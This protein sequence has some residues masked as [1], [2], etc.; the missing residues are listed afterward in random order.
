MKVE[1]FMV[2]VEYDT[3]APLVIIVNTFDEAME[4]KKEVKECYR[5]GVHKFSG[6]GPATEILTEVNRG[7]K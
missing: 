4:L 7:K 2:V 3:I 5:V 1:K 6:N